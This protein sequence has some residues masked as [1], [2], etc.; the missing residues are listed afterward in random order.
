L[1]SKNNNKALSPLCGDDH[2]NTWA[3]KRSSYRI[4]FTNAEKNWNHFSFYIV[5]IATQSGDKAF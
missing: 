1:Y 3:L 5:C 4:S 2:I